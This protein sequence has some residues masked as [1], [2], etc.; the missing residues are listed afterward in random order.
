MPEQTVMYRRKFRTSPTALSH[1]STKN[2]FNSPSKQMRC[3]KAASQL[4]RCINFKFFMLVATV[5]SVGAEE[6]NSTI[7]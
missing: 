3:A 2:H 7:D 6:Y 5:W 1:D 4:Q